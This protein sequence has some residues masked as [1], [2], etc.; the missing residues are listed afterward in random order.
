MRRTKNKKGPK[1][2][3]RNIL[4]LPGE[5][6][7][8]YVIVDGRQVEQVS[9]LRYLGFA[10]DESDLQKVTVAIRSLMSATCL[11]KEFERMML[12]SLF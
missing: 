1:H 9:E 12:E 3:G 7:L 8:H 10:L 4:L 6:S 5:G 2:R 11:R